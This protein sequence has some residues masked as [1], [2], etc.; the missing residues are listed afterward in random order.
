MRITAPIALLLA[1]AAAFAAAPGVGDAWRA[2]QAHDPAYAAAQAQR[3]AGRAQAAEGRALWLPS[4]S[5]TGSTGRGDLR[6]STQGAWFAAPG[7]GSTNGVAFRTSIRDGTATR[8]A[9]TAEQPL[10]DLGRRADSAARK[11]AAHSAESR[12]SAVQQELMIRTARSYFGVLDAR[13][14]LGGLRQLRAAAERARAAAQ[15]RYE[16]G[17]IAATD[18]REATAAADAIDVQELDARAALTLA[19]ADFSD[20]TGLDAATLADLPE[21]AT[22]DMPAPEPLEIWTQR[23]LENSPQL[24]IARLALKTAQAE[25]TRNAALASPQLSLV[26]QV[27]NDQLHGDGDFGYAEVNGRNA[28]IGV[29]ATIPLF[30]GGMRSARRHEARAQER[31]AQA[32]L[33]GAELQVRQQVRSSYLA[34]VNAAARVQALQRLR[35]SAASR[36]AATQLGADIG[37]RTTVDLLNAQADAMRA[38]ADFRHAQAEWLLAGLQLGVSAGQLTTAGL[39]EIDRRLQAAGAAAN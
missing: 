21:G 11:D 4:V 29:Q 19:E 23:A 9:I 36:L 27:A 22:A 2:A 34:L 5:A 24:A 28:S 37:D 39:D 7:F 17:D 16:A 8:W 33:E 25:V 35:A 15:A 38:D 14:Q 13:A 20:L 3:D 30:T 6:S 31:A 32:A 10:F 1:N 26:A 18:M 12:Y